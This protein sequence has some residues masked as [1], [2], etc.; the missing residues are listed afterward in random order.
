MYAQVEKAKENKSRAVGNSVGQKK[1]NAKQGFGLINNRPV[2]GI[3]FMSS[4]NIPHGTV[5]KKVNNKGA[6]CNCSICSSSNGSVQLKQKETKENI[7]SKNIIQM[8]PICLD[9]TCLKGEKC[10]KNTT[11]DGLFPQA[12]EQDRVMKHKDTKK[13]SQKGVFESEH[14]I[15]SSS[16]K[17]VNP[18]Y[19]PNEAYTMSIPYMTHQGGASGIGGG[20]STSKNSDTAKQTSN[21]YSQMMQ[22]NNNFGTV[23]QAVMDE[24]NAAF[25]NNDLTDGRGSQIIQYVNSQ[26][27]TNFIT[28]QEGETIIAEGTNHFYNM[29]QL[30]DNLQ[31]K[32]I[33][34][35]K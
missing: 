29:R 6:V 14:P 16:M 25:Q 11:L 7:V 8:C 5:Q 9:M 30:Y 24:I 15:S 22:Q 10:K 31:N 17:K 28:Q 33:N 27:M 13:L 18:N 2:G 12:T 19:N 20:I 21:Y 4:N 34:Y 23:R 1:S 26:V 35:K 3:K 32:N